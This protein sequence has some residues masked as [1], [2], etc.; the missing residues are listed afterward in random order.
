[1]E[2]GKGKKTVITS[3]FLPRVSAVHGAFMLVA[4]RLRD[5]IFLPSRRHHVTLHKVIKGILGFLPIAFGAYSLG[6]Y[7]S[8]PIDY[9]Q[10]VHSL[11]SE[12]QLYSF[13]DQGYP[14]LTLHHVTGELLCEVM[15]PV[16]AQAAYQYGQ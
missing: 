11:E 4:L 2:P 13:L 16:F 12:D 8:N 10:F 14:V 1:M 9:S 7:L 15:T 5:L 6:V 3:R